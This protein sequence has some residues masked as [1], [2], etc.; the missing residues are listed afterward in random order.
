MAADQGRAAPELLLYSAMD[1]T[2][3]SPANSRGLLAWHPSYRSVAATGCVAGG[4][5]DAP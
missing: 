3:P 1:Q 5:D 2:C 4:I